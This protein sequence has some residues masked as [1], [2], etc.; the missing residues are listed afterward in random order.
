LEQRAEALLTEAFP[1]GLIVPVDIDFLAEGHLGL[2]IVPIPSLE[3]NHDLWGSLWKARDGQ[4][5]IIVDQHVLDD[6]P[7]LYRFTLGEEIAHYVLHRAHFAEVQTVEQACEV[8]R[9]LQADLHHMERNAKWF[10]SALL[11][12]RRLV[13]EEAARLYG[14]L[15][16]YVGY[17]N[18]DAVLK[19][20]TGLLA[21]QF[22]VSQQAMKYR[23]D[24]HPCR[25]TEAVQTAMASH[26]A[27]LWEGT[28]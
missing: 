14:Q 3:A 28:R 9:A 7:N 13:R 8:Q 12:P 22:R 18:A 17:A 27:S 5:K 21:R 26:D 10:A 15:V 16:A 6:Q 2:E 24:D 19:K 11:M 25:V 20:L 1:A 4:H 23:L